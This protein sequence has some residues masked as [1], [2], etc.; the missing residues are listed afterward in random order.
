MT[1]SF[2][3]S[4]AAAGGGAPGMGPAPGDAAVPGGL[5]EGTAGNSVTLAAGGGGGRCSRCQ[6]SQRN[7]A[8]SEKMT[9]RI[10]RCVSMAALLGGGCGWAMRW[11]AGQGTGS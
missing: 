5:A 4:G 8:E 6:A 1:I 3:A 11:G 9:N 7:S 10:S 2:G